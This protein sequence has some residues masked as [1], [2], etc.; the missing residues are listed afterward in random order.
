M[1]KERDF[2]REKC[3]KKEGQRHPLPPQIFNDEQYRGVT[4]AILNSTPRS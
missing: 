1:E 3:K 2:M 4:E